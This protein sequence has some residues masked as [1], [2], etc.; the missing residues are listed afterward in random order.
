MRKKEKGDEGLT[1]ATHALVIPLPI[2]VL[3][4]LLVGG[5]G[6]CCC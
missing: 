4:V 1:E 5:D 6:C 2:I 3:T